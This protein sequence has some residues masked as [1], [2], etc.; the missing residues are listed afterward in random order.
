MGD[1][2]NEIEV[3][4]FDGSIEEPVGIFSVS[5]RSSNVFRLGSIVIHDFDGGC[6]T[7]SSSDFPQDDTSL[8]FN[9][10]FPI[11]IPVSPAL[12]SSVGIESV[13][14]SWTP[15]ST[16]P[17]YQIWK[18]IGSGSFVK[19]VPNHN[20]NSYTDSDVVGNQTYSYYVVLEFDE[21]LYTSNIVQ[22]VTASPLSPTLSRMGADNSSVDLSWTASSGATSYRIY[23]KALNGSYG[24][25]IIVS[26]TTFNESIVADD[27]FTYKVTAVDN[28]QSPDSNEVIAAPISNFSFSLQSLIGAQVSVTRTVASNATAYTLFYKKTANPTYLSVIN[29]TNPY[30]GQYS[31]LTDYSYYMTAENSEGYSS[32]TSVQTLVTS[33]TAWISVTAPFLTNSSL[34]AIMN[35]RIMMS[36]S[37]GKYHYSDDLG[38]NWTTVN[39]NDWIGSSMIKIAA[40]PD[41]NRWYMMGGGQ[42]TTS[43]NPT[44]GAS[45]SARITSPAATIVTTTGNN[46]M[47]G[48]GITFNNASQLS[49]KYAQYSSTNGA[50]GTSGLGTIG[51]KSLSDMT[52]GNGIFIVCGEIGNGSTDGAPL[53]GGTPIMRSTDGTSW[54]EITFPNGQPKSFKTVTYGGSNKFVSIMDSSSVRRSSVSYDGGLT[55]TTYSNLPASLSAGSGGTWNKMAYGDGKFVV[56]GRNSAAYSYNGITWN[57]MSNV[58]TGEW[59]S[60]IYTGT[61]FVAVANDQVGFTTAGKN[62]MIWNG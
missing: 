23:K 8:I 13:N 45:W 30:T 56:V 47:Y 42:Y 36:N 32:T 41:E 26:G 16:M 39:M 1:P 37:N 38:Y 5:I 49:T 19:I 52:F 6:L 40:A 51:P 20:T 21:D 53:G 62:V 14:L 18:K 50:L 2:E 29:P 54:T 28:F 58:P 57:M 25:P 22:Q 10:N 46:K 9:I 15:L 43:N 12:T 61:S 4:K 33:E 7:I 24:S 59:N 11:E 3:V 17:D 55:W 44:S 48:M 35:N 31:G 27:Y 34:L 60:I